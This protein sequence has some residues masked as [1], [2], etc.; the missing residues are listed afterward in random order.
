MLSPKGRIWS[1]CW[2]H[3]LANA[4][5]GVWRWLF[6]PQ[7]VYEVCR[8]VDSHRAAGAF[9]RD[10]LP[11][12]F[13]IQTPVVQGQLP[14]SSKAILGSGNSVPAMTQRVPSKWIVSG[15]GWPMNALL[16]P[17]INPTLGGLAI[18]PW[19]SEWCCCLNTM[20]RFSK[21]VEDSRPA[22]AA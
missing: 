11:S 17:P 15:C 18:G 4:T 22:G 16:P 20:V 2:K 12:K 1:S 10:G 14:A 6:G 9:T 8:P 21:R 13:S 5:T 19:C 7:K 3:T